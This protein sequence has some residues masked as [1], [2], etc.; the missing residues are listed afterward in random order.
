MNTRMALNMPKEKNIELNSYSDS[1]FQTKM[2]SFSPRKPQNSSP[3]KSMK[4][5]KY[6]STNKFM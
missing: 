5:A 4:K 6:S 2:S 3:Y 1:R